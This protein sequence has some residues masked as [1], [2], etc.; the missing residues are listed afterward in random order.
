MLSQGFH[1]ISIP[2]QMDFQTSL[3]EIAQQ[4]RGFLQGRQNPL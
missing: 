4:A 3:D 1:S 2:Y